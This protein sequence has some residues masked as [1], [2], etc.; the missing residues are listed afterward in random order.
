MV[1]VIQKCVLAAMVIIV[2][3]FM[4]ACAGMVNAQDDITTVL[5]VIEN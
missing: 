3:V 1:D 2:I 4:N 5:Q